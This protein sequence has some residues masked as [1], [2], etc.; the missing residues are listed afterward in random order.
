MAVDGWRPVP[1]QE[2]FAFATVLDPIR[3]GVTVHVKSLSNEGERHVAE[4]IEYGTY[5][6]DALGMAVDGCIERLKK[7][8]PQ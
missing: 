4:F 6:A 1:E 3:Q 7:E 8:N 5:T 2:G